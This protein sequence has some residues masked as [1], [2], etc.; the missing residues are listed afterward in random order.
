MHRRHRLA[1]TTG[2]ILTLLG[3][4]LVA[5]PCL[6]GSQAG[7]IAHGRYL[8]VIAGCNDCHTPGWLKTG[9]QV[10]EAHWLTGGDFGWHGPWGT[11]YAANLR[12]LL[13]TMSEAQWVHYA[14]TLHARPP[15][16]SWALHTMN[17]A[18]LRAIYAFVL[19]LGP[20]GQKAPAY[21]P[22]GGKITTPWVDFDV[23][24]SPAQ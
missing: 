9:G 14:H 10:P 5:P 17:D 1:T 4:L 22:P 7:N 13:P 20:A 3:S 2:I 19:K 21:V 12:L 8:S 11:T 23:R 18:D 6:A 16:P 15:M 24:P